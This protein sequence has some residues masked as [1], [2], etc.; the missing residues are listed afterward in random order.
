MNLIDQNLRSIKQRIEAA[1]AAAGRQKNSVKLLAVSKKQPIEAILQAYDAGQRSFGESY[2]QESLEKIMALADHA[3]EW[4]F[5][6]P[7]QSNKTHGI[8]AHFSWVHSVS[9]L[10][11]AIRLS[12]QRPPELGNL[13]LCLQLNISGETSKSGASADELPGLASEIAAL[14]RLSVRG[15][16]TIPRYSDAPNQQRQQCAD[17]QRLYQSLQTQHPQLDT[18]SMGMSGDMEIAIEQG[19]TIVRIGTALFGS[20]N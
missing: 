3:I 12:D 2:L 19:A 20:R 9:H 1:E 17:T 18:L 10:K 14:P 4:H 8:A 5:I 15:L 13:N 6:G 7:I 16:M 11:Q